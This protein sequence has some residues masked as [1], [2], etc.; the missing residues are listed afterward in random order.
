VDDEEYMTDMAQEMLST[1]GYRVVTK[2]VSYEALAFVRE[3]PHRVDLVITDQTMPGMTGDVLIQKLWQ[4]RPD[5]PVILC[6]GFNDLITPES[7]Q[8][9]GIRHYVMKPYNK[10]DMALKIREALGPGIT[11]D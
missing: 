4:I 8:K 6:T 1:L 2:T 10:K 3:N 9:M 5:L 11:A 7:A